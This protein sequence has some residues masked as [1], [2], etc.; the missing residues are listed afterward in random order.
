MR[1]MLLGALTGLIL[2]LA[3]V[4]STAAQSVSHQPPEGAGGRLLLPRGR[5]LWQ[6]A[7]S[8]AVE[9]RLLAGEPLTAITQASWS[10]DGRQV[11]YALFRFWRPDRP[12]G[13]DLYLLDSASGQPAPVL[14]GL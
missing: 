6:V 4:V 3:P 2:L 1:Q 11:A 7:A 8:S 9:Q 10:P 12:A 5:D 14:S 13:S